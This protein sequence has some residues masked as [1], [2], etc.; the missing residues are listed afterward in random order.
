MHA[1][2]I[3]RSISSGD[4]HRPHD[5]TLPTDVCGTKEQIML[6]LTSTGVPNSRDHTTCS[7]VQEG[8]TGLPPRSQDGNRQKTR[9]SRWAHL[10]P[11]GGLRCEEAVMKLTDVDV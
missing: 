2:W 6:L 10:H 7:P 11:A 8:T 1:G 4:L 5:V 9:M 3:L